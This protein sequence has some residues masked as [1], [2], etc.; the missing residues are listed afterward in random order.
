VAGLL[1]AAGVTPGQAARTGAVAPSDL[2][3]L[4]TGMTVLVSCWD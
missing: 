3:D 1:A 2:A 4:G